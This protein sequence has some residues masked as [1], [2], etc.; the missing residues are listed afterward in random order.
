MSKISTIAI[1]GAGISGLSAGGLL[2]RQGLRVKLFEANAKVGGS[3][4]TT[5]LGGYTFND[6]ALYLAF[7]NLLDHV[8]AKLDRDRAALLPLRKIVANQTTILPDASVVT[9]GDGLDV[10]VRKCKGTVNGAQLEQELRRMMQR[11]EPVLHLFA[12]DIILHP[13]SLSRLI[14][15]GWRHL[16]KLRGTVAAELDQ[17]I[18]DEAVRA[19]MAGMLLYTGLPPQRTPALTLLGLITMFS[20]GFYLPEGGMGRIPEVLGQCVRD[21]G[22]EVYLDAKVRKIIV[23][24]ERVRGLEVDG[25]GLVEAD[26]VISTVS[27]MVTVDTLLDPADVPNSMR[28]E[29]QSA[30]LSHKVLAVQL[31]LSKRIDAPSHANSI[32]PMMDRQIEFFDPSDHEVKWLHYTA[33]TVTMPEL[34]PQGTSI[35]EMY[36]PIRQ[37]VPA[38][39]WD[40]EKRQIAVDAAIQAL[41]RVHDIDVHVDRVLGPKE[42]Q[43]RMHL[44]RGAVYGLSPAAG[45]SALFPHS[46]PIRGL[47]QAGQTTYPGFGIGPAA[48]SGVFAGEKLLKMAGA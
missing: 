13:F 18:S 33:P 39:Y 47:F 15:K 10:T 9:F 40:H 30:P 25:H 20:Q 14:R 24:D 43:E 17:L 2:S 7:P 21:N 34:A 44:Y 16:P 1:I 31:G 19:A 28:R 26:A 46:P 41:S 27:G 36:P 22:G 48:I 3:C 42:F 35:V 4:G 29:V 12:D 6:G 37:D 11:W 32:L 5:R 38:G 23:R 8:F 45:P